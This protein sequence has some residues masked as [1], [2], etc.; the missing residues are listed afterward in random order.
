MFNNFEAVEISDARK[1]QELPEMRR[2][3]ASEEHFGT[4]VVDVGVHPSA[5]CLEGL[6]I[7]FF[8]AQLWVDM[9]SFLIVVDPAQF[10]QNNTFMIYKK[11][12]WRGR[13]L[14]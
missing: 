4:S 5:P 3:V 11:Q 12:T 8:C 13:T 6:S 2:R 1:V 10:N 7:G 14:R 9:A